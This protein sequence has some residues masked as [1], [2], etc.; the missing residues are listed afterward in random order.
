M[1]PALLKE[2]V[3]GIFSRPVTIQYPK[4][5]TVI[6]PD[7]RGRQYADLRKCVGC[8]LCAVECPSNAITMTKIP[9]GYEVPKTNARKIYPVINYFKCVFCYRCVTVCPTNAYTVSNDYRLAS[10]APTDSSNLSLST[11]PKAGGV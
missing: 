4:E 10:P 6:E 1:R 3:R 2:I 11:T 7:F 5:Q 8:S 9:D